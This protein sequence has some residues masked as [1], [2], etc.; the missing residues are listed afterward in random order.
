M[1]S[2]LLVAALSVFAATPASAFV[3][4]DFDGGGDVN[5]ADAISMLA[6]LFQTGAPPA[7]C[8][9]AADVND[10]GALDISDPIFLLAA[11]FQAGSLP[12][13]PFPADG[14]D[15]TADSLPPCSPGGLL[16]FTTIAQGPDSGLV[17]FLQ[18]VILDAG[19]WS[20]FWSAHSS[21]PLPAVDFASE[22]VVVVMGTFNGF[23]VTYTI[24]EIEVVGG[25]LEIRYT[26]VL[27]GVY[28]PEQIEPH[29]IVRT[30]RTLETPV[31]LET[32]IALP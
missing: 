14:V 2:L 24:D 26:V 31:F 7:P 22:M 13:P 1:R 17:T 8:A 16:P 12:P 29:H 9:D 6:M 19:E 28:L 18:S 30:V 15:P 32:T 21:D 5:I 3:R 10:D 23:G 27:P 4:G 11:L 20:T 25:A